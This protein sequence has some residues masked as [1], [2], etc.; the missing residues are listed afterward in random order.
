MHRKATDSLVAPRVGSSNGAEI[1]LNEE[2]RRIGG[3]EHLDA[4]VDEVFRMMVGVTCQ[5]IAE[6]DWSGRELVTAV[7]GFGGLMS[8]ACVLRCDKRDATR[9]AS[10]LAADSFVDLDDTV[11]DA[12]GEIGNMLAGTWKGK[13]PE[14]AARCGL[15]LPTVISGHDYELHV[16]ASEF[17]LRHTYSFDE[18]SFEVMI[19]CDAV[20]WKEFGSIC[21][22][23]TRGAAK[24]RSQ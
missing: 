13:I 14:L 15:S 18:S 24:H 21:R 23:Q 12:I 11:K 5:R 6:R 2:R 20:Q 1:Y 10:C 8:G 16:Q 9:I 7:V 4:S 19:L 22:V 3:P 17:E